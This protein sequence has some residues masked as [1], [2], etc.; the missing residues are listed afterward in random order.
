MHGAVVTVKVLVVEHVEVVSTARP[1]EAV[2][3][4][5][6]VV[7]VGILM[8]ENKPARRPSHSR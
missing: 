3:A 6:E 8:M 7:T 5:Q 2:V 4:L 1:L